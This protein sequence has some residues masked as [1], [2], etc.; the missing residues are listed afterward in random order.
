MYEDGSESIMPSVGFRF[1]MAI[2][3]TFAKNQSIPG[4]VDPR[5]CKGVCVGIGVGMDIGASDCICG[6]IGTG[7]GA[8][9]RICGY[10]GAGTGIGLLTEL[11]GDVVSAIL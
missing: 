10:F 5:D 1:R 8:G 7:T 6:L 9:F 2:A 4:E 3:L 11:L